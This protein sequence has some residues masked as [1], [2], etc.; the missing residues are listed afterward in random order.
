MDTAIQSQIRETF[1]KVRDHSIHLRTSSLKQRIDKVRKLEKWI[2]SNRSLIH[3]ALHQDLQKPSE[4]ADLTE[5]FVVLSEIRK[6]R[7]NLKSWMAPRQV[8]ASL[9][10]LGTKSYVAY[11]PMGACLII[12]P[13]NYPFQLAIGPLISAIAAGNSVILKPSEISEN[14][15]NLIKSMCQDLFDPEEVSVVLGAV[16]ETQELLTLPFDHIF[17]IFI[18]IFFS[19]T[20]LTYVEFSIRGRRPLPH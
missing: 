9:T 20:L 5:V 12:A 19:I 16:D 3:K 7:K 8:S 10:F 4:E 1:H 14:T 18:V 15:A 6:V 11:E 13:W 17:F 2:L